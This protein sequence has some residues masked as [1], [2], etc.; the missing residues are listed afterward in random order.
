MDTDGQ[1]NSQNES[2]S[3]ESAEVG[4]AMDSL[5]DRVRDLK[6]TVTSLYAQGAGL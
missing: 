1:E 5:A 4:K 3:K 2:R 6:T